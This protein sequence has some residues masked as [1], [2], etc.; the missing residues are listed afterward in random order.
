MNVTMGI[1]DKCGVSGDATFCVVIFIL[2]IFGQ[3]KICQNHPISHIILRSAGLTS[4]EV[5]F[6]LLNT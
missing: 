5:P 1:I 2:A 4:D 3:D 6:P